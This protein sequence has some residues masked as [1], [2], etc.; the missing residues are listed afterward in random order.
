[1]EKMLI[2]SDAVVIPGENSPSDEPFTKPH[3]PG[4]ASVWVLLFQD[5]ILPNS[6][7]SSLPVCMLR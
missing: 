3:A 6:T 4:Y 2:L 5:D 7:M 1:M